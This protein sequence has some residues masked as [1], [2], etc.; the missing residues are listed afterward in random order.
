MGANDNTEISQMQDVI[1]KK[2][3]PFIQFSVEKDEMIDLN[4]NISRIKGCIDS[5]EKSLAL[6]YVQELLNNWHH[7]NK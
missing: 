1:E 2:I 6:V 4:I 3:F 5:K 7:L